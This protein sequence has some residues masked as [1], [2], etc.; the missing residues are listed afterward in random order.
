MTKLALEVRKAT[1][2]SPVEP[3]LGSIGVNI[4]T[5]YKDYNVR[6][7]DKAGYVI[8]VEITV[9]YVGLSPFFPSVPVNFDK[10]SSFLFL[11][12]FLRFFSLVG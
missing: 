1:P 8:H 6:T 5:F 9:Y 7:V 11:I 2:A 4:M 3:A 12:L 10:M